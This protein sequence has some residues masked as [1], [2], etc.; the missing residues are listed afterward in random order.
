MIGSG[1]NSR[2]PV[3]RPAR[4][5]TTEFDRLISELI[6]KWELLGGAVGVVESGRLVVAR[7]Y[8]YAD[9]ERTIPV[10]PEMGFRIASVSKP[11]TAVAVL[12]LVDHGYLSLDDRA[13]AF[14][15]DIVSPA[16]V[17]DH[18][19]QDITIR[20]LLQHS[21]GWETDGYDPMFETTEIA[22]AAG[23]SPPAGP[24][25]IIRHMF[26]QELDFTPGTK[27]VY[28]NFGYCILGRIIERVTGE[29]YESA[30][31]STILDEVGSSGMHVGHSSPDQRAPG[32]VAYESNSDAAS[33]F[34]N[35]GTVPFADGGFHLEGMDAHGDGLL[36]LS[37][38]YG[39]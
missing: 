18:R 12:R 2:L 34:P 25:T 8:G 3:T 6:T 21:A 20:M 14:L 37:T 31:Q 11:I 38:S 13:M 29:S 22:R 4:P 17:A 1:P 26:A 24:S 10:S 19:V 15:D 9:V 7:G 16:A 36:R 30:I 35:G 32:E 23:T 28:S 33:V 5:G 27:H 39:L